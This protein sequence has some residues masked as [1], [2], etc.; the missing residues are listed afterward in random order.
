MSQSTQNQ[1][2]SKILEKTLTASIKK[3]IAAIGINI[4]TRQGNRELKFLSRKIAKY[5]FDNLEQAQMAGTLLGQQLAEI[6]QQRGKKNLDA[7]II[8]Q[9]LY[10]RKLFSLAGLS[11]KESQPDKSTLYSSYKEDSIS[12]DREQPTEEIQLTDKAFSDKVS[13]LEEAEVNPEEATQEFQPSEEISVSSEDSSADARA[14]IKN[15]Q[16]T[17]ETSLLEEAEID[18]EEPIQET[19]IHQA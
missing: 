15:S 10:Q 1:L 11:T 9:M 14:A 18:T 4:S 6:S 13:L 19:P 17:E 5:P 2:S 8:Q 16:I 3:E 12:V 7:G